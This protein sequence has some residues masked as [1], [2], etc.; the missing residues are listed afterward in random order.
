VAKVQRI[1]II[2][3]SLAGLR[4]AE[5]LRQHGFAGK[6]TLVGAEPHLP[7]DR[8]PL[9]KQVLL[10]T[11][12]PD[13]AFFRR[14]VGYESLALDLRL[15][16]QATSLDVRNRLVELSEGPPLEFDGLIVATGARVKTLPHM[17]DLAGLHVLRGL[18]DARRLRD[19]LAAARRVV[20]VGAGLIG[21][22][23]AAS[24][25]ARGLEVTAVEA[26]PVPL[27][28]VL[29]EAAGRSIVDFH[30]QKG[31]TVHTATTVTGIHGGAR[32]E[33]VE[34]ADG[35]R[36]EADVVVV[37]IGVRPNVEWLADSGLTLDDGV[38]CDEYCMA[39][40]SIYAAGDV[41]R[42]KNPWCDEVM[43]V[44]H[45]TNAAEQAYVAA[46]NLLAAEAQRTPFASAPYFW[47][48]QYDRKVQ[49]AGRCRGHD[50]F[51][52]VDGSLA[53]LKLTALY[54]RAGRLVGVL[55]INQPRRLIQFRRLLLEVT[56]FEAA[57][58]APP[59]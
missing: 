51:R 27:S 33:G 39:A 18:D 26:L 41:A 47:S 21:L 37:G 6:L 46:G 4:A 13:Q 20:I 7:Y 35:S 8:P 2:G 38:V 16:V 50:E 49:F 43:R 54:G 52:V 45:W 29:G 15:G 23:V 31:V 56:P 24:C 9:S 36:I 48:D 14:K 55:A 22:E 40:P 57:V 59:S 30:R 32:V 58:S 1:A 42:W 34:L 5:A 19:D 12:S 10:G 53:E 3:A 17:P 44:E 11:W 28:P 25:R